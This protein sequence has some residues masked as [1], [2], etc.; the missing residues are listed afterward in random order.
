[1]K[2]ILLIMLFFISPN[3][4]GQVKPVNFNDCKY[5]M[6]FVSADT[7]PL[8]KDSLSITNYLHQF[9]EKHSVSLNKDINGK[10]VLGIVIYEDGHTCCQSFFDLTKNQLDP[11][12]F[13]DAVNNMPNWMPAK[14][15]GKE[16]IFLKN[17]IIEIKDG[18]FFE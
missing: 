4:F 9:F 6:V 1:M 5:D 10:I 3:L 11:V 17:Q 12:V 2:I 13:K 15:N 8:W 14:Q 18:M 7:Q 16:I